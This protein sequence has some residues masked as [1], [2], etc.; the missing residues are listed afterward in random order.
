MAQFTT[1]LDEALEHFGRA[2]E[3]LAG[4]E[5]TPALVDSL[6]GQ[7]VALLNTERFGEASQTGHRALETARAIGYPSGEAYACGNLSMGAQYTGDYPAALVWA[8]AALRVDARQVSG[9]SARWA[10]L[11]L[12]FALAETGDLPAAEA[13]FNDV[14]DLC[15]SAGER[16]WEAMV[17]ESLARIYLT[18][19]RRAAAGPYL[20]E[21]LRIASEVGNRLRLADCL[22]TAAVWAADHDPESAAV[23]WGASCA[24]SKALGFNRLPIT[25]I[26]NSADEGSAADSLFYT[27]PV[28]AVRARLGPQRARMAGQRGA[29]M[30]FE[31]ILEF[32]RRVLSE[33]ALSTAGTAV[34]ASGLTKRERELVALVAQGLSNA[35]IAA[36]LFISERTVGSHLD[37]IRAKTGCRRRADLT[38]L[39][40]QAG[41]V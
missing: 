24:L 3:L 40:L 5:A 33:G 39:A 32:V 27:T 12:P 17:L 38:R 28:L 4:Q 2:E 1:R 21:A 13:A 19:G 41:L 22:G 11:M 14:L 37:R 16:S 35:Q 20:G 7:V 31:A 36:R 25:D 23:L 15:R 9:H 10:A 18:T 30:S 8:Q 29:D 34:P 6:N 26:T